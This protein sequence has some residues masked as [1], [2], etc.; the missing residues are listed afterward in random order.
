MFTLVCWNKICI[1]V[2]CNLPTKSQH[3]DESTGQIADS[4]VISQATEVVP[5]AAT[6]TVPVVSLATLSAVELPL[7]RP[8]VT[9]TLLLDKRAVVVV[10]AVISN[11]T[12]NITC[13]EDTLHY[14]SSS[15]AGRTA[16]YQRW[17]SLRNLRWRQHRISHSRL[18]W[19][20]LASR[21]HA[22]D[23]EHRYDV[24]Q[25]TVIERDIVHS[26]FSLHSSV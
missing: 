5:L 26:T 7:F 11:W 9:A 24:R 21:S 22:T 14:I 2:L 15:I 4:E 16:D 8:L 20:S 19:C 6:A 12:N 23:G 10:T 17:K 13:W 25:V 3:S 1:Y 18:A